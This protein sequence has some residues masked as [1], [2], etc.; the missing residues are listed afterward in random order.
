MLFVE[1]ARRQP[2]S[3]EAVSE[4]FLSLHA[5]A[6][7]KSGQLV[8]KCRRG[9]LGQAHPIRII[10]GKSAPRTAVERLAVAQRPLAIEMSDEIALLHR[11]A[12]PPFPRL[13]AGRTRWRFCAALK[14]IKVFSNARRFAHTF[15][16]LHVADRRR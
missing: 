15:I 14:A 2:R 9:E 11:I 6:A 4:K 13:Q 5:L 8:G 3:D 12:R 1:E 10:V 7:I 16:Q